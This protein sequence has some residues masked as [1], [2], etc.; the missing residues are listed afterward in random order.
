MSL[1]AGQLRELARIAGG[2]LDEA[3]PYFISE[4]GAK[5]EV[6]KGVGDWA[7]AADLALERQITAALTERTGLSMH[8]E[9]F[10]G[11]DLHTGVTWVLDPID[12]TANY[13]AR[14]PLTG[15]SLA[16]LEEGRPVV[17]L[18]R[19]PMFGEAY[20]AIDGGPLERNGEAMPTLQPAGLD[21]VT[22]A[23]GNVAPKGTH[24]GPTPRY[25]FRYR[26]ALANAIAH[27]ALRV[28]MFGSS[29]V[30]LAWAAS[31][32]VGAALNFGNHAW[33]NAAGALLLRQ[34]GGE[35]RDLEGGEWSLR[36]RSILVGRP[37][38]VGELADLL[39]ALGDPASYA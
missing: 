22:I 21:D 34:A 39:A 10:G 19:L 26:M 38:V 7:T 6:V 11:P 3:T 23:L 16:L 24:G 36:S 15:I 14:I 31:G 32:A 28:R 12:G 20:Q 33:D 1:D 30:E 37:G 2:V 25:P 29:A 4:I 27:Q 8:G 13:T 9:E 5:E 35:L 18:I 17:G